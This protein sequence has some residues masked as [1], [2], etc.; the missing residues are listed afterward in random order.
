MQ[1][2]SFAKSLQNLQLVEGILKRLEMLRTR[3][4]FKQKLWDNVNKLNL[5]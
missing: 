5:D 1:I 4:E 2:Q 3:P